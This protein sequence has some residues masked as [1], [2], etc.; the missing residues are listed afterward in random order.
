MPVQVSA[1]RYQRRA[2]TRTEHSKCESG[3]HGSF[4]RLELRR[5]RRIIR[6]GVRRN[7]EA[8]RLRFKDA[9]KH[10]RRDAH[11][12]RGADLRHRLEQ[13]SRYALFVRERDLSD[14]QCPRRECEVRAEDDKTRCWEA[15]CP[16]GRARVDHCE[17]DVSAACH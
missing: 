11:A 5:Q 16:V 12:N 7:A 8:P 6:L 15:E 4:V 13:R 1:R 14:E 2:K 3:P 9:I 10:D 17:E